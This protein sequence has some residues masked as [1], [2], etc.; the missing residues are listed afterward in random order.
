M[1]IL[2]LSMPDS[3]E[4]TPTVAIRMPNGALASLAGNLDP[5]HVVAIAD[6]VLVQRRSAPTVE[7]LMRDLQPGGRRAVGDDVSARDGA[8]HHLARPVARARRAHRRRR[9]RSEPG[10]GGVDDPGLGV[11]AIVRGEGDVTF[12]RVV[13]ALERTRRRSTR[14]RTVVSRR[15]TAFAGTAPAAVTAVEDGTSGLPIGRARAV[16]LHVA[17]PQHGRGRDVARVHVRLQLLFDHRDARAQLPSLADGAG[18]RRH[19]RCRAPRRAD[20]LLRRRQHHAGRR[21]VQ[22]A[23]PGHHRCGPRRHRLHGAGMTSPIAAHGAELAP[24][25]RRAGFR[26]VFLGIENIL[27]EDLGFLKA[28]AKNSQREHRRRVGNAS[29]AAVDDAAQH[30]MFVIGGLIVGNPDDTRGGDRSEPG[31]RQKVRGLALHPASHAV[32]RDADD[33]GFRR[34]RPRR[35]SPR[36]R[37]RRHDGGDAEHAPRRGGDRVHAVEGRAMDEAPALCRLRFVTIRGLSIRHGRADAGAYLPRI[38]VAIAGRTRERRTVFGRYRAHR[39]REREYV[40]WPDPMSDK[41]VDGPVL[42]G[43]VRVHVTVGQLL[44]RATHVLPR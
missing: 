43:A 33:A 11:D 9:L 12:R 40:E 15:R 27:D 23:L 32:S 10:T 36:R 41:G 20:D 1:Q 2:L 31:L 38:D 6:L 8:A 17:G 42:S 18:D 24:L 29:T 28:A 4:H 35:Q 34:A 39:A 25:M 13:R 3:F 5:H 16:R 30:G 21:A 22:G 7:R 19:P 37:V 14:R 26:Y 44:S